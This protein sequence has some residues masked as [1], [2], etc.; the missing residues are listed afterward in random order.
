MKHDSTTN[1]IIYHARAQRDFIN[2]IPIE[3]LMTWPSGRI[4]PFSSLD[5]YKFSMM[6]AQAM[7]VAI[8]GG[9]VY[10]TAD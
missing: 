3:E 8:F 9:D 6:P 5:D 10:D 4:N 1:A 7:E 2:Q